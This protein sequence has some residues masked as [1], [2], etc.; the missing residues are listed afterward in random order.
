[1]ILSRI[2]LDTAAISTKLAIAN[3]QKMHA[4]VEE[5]VNNAER[6]LWR[7]DELSA[8]VYLLILSP[9]APDFSHFKYGY[10]GESR[11]YSAV[12][13]Q[14]ESGKLLNFRLCANPTYTK[15]A[16]TGNR[17]KICAHVTIEQRRKWLLDKA[18]KWGFNLNED[19]FEIIVSDNISFR[20]KQGAKP[21]ELG[22]AVY[23]G[24][25]TVTDTELFKKALT[26][27]IGRAKAYG[28]GMLTVVRQR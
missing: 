13:Q 2:K 14:I 16:G 8:S 25:L 9:N 17:G 18:C 12:L 24:L 5:C 1:M 26:D 4:A 15:S 28:C 11:D 20:K 22:I 27:G 19:D 21:V 23:E 10:N 3:P 7:I 6:K